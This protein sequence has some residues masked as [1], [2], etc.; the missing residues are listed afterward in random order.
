MQ[1]Y[2]NI[3]CIAKAAIEIQ[4]RTGVYSYAK[5]LALELS[6]DPGVGFTLLQGGWEYFA[7]AADPTDLKLR[8]NTLQGFQGF[9]SQAVFQTSFA[10]ASRT[11]ARW[12]KWIS[13]L[14]PRGSGIRALH[15]PWFGK[16][17]RWS[18]NSRRWKR[19][20]TVH[21]LIA[22]RHPEWFEPKVLGY[23]DRWSKWIREADLIICPSIATQND[24]L[25]YFPEICKEMTSVVYLG[26]SFSSYPVSPEKQLLRLPQSLEGGDFL[27]SVCTLEPRKNL[28][29]L[30]ESYKIF[31]EQTRSECKLALVGGSGWGESVQP[32]IDG[33]GRFA[34]DVIVT[35]YVSDE[36]LP[37]LYRHALAFVYPSL[38]EGFGL[39][40]LDALTMG[41]P[42]ITS[43]ISSIPEIAGDAAV[44]VD[45]TSVE[46][47][48]NALCRVVEDS[49]LRKRLS[50]DGLSRA[51]QFSWKRCAE[52]TKAAYARALAQ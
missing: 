13:G 40:V 32:I 12:E 7:K 52:E 10:K 27:L 21:D 20:L 3:S 6:E 34:K 41:A 31:K 1:S 30:L 36:I 4:S 17:P 22:W 8:K 44:M 45:P 29:R 35:G 15:Q 14:Q 47:I 46:E 50:A 43:N 48:S 28:K 42:V 23:R 38:Y 11:C 25:H 18:L 16:W 33:L 2:I 39:P 49:E 5:N 19:C 51:S 9:T 26:A 24:L 37:L